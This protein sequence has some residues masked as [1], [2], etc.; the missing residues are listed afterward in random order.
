M[1]GRR[2]SPAPMPTAT[3]PVSTAPPA[4]Q[5]EV[6]DQPGGNQAVLDELLAGGL[7]DP[8]GGGF[9]ADLVADGA[10]R[11]GRD[12]PGIGDG[13]ELGANDPTQDLQQDPTLGQ[14]DGF[15]SGGTPDFDFG[16]DFVSDVDPQSAASEKPAT[17]GGHKLFPGETKEEQYDNVADSLAWTGGAMLAG[18]GAIGAAPAWVTAGTVITVAAGGLSLLGALTGTTDDIIDAAADAGVDSDEETAAKGAA[19]RQAGEERKKAKQAAGSDDASTDS[20]G[21]HSSSDDSQ[22]GSDSS[23]D[24]SDSDGA[25]TD[26]DVEA[27]SDASDSTDGTNGGESEPDYVD[28]T[29][30]EAMAFAAHIEEVTHAF[31]IMTNAKLFGEI[32]PEDDTG[33]DLGATVSAGLMSMIDSDEDCITVGGGPDD[34]AVPDVDVD[35][36]IGDLIQFT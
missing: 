20:D 10:H 12:Q 14:L 17:I 24:S 11:G 3:A 16:S 4:S 13:T 34:M 9:L 18:A 32:N 36:G 19:G 26:A 35:S 7:V 2:R 30:P 31:E 23:T 8:D 33:N 6:V 5:T 21:D 29:S 1:R 27:D 22:S 15:Y 28:P 25:D